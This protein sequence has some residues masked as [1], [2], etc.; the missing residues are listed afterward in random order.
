[1]IDAQELVKRVD[2]N[3]GFDRSRL[4]FNDGLGF[5]EVDESAAAISGLRLVGFSLPISHF[6]GIDH[7]ET[8]H[9]ITDFGELPA[10][11]RTID[12][13]GKGVGPRLY[14]TWQSLAGSRVKPD[15]VG[16]YAVDIDPSKLLDLRSVQGG[17]A[18]QIARHAGRIVRSKLTSIE[19][20]VNSI[21]ESYGEADAV[22][23]RMPPHPVIRQLQHG[24]KN[25]VEPQF[26]IIRNK[27]ILMRRV[28]TA[29]TPW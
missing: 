9:P 17:R 13:Q 2:F 27:H 14:N 4:R 10:D 25:P 29:P 18:L 23:L 8:V 19:K 24:I 12:A 21:H 15:N 16:V 6:G 26:I 20:V 11:S 1:M 3:L 5:L 22:E 28:G 7:S